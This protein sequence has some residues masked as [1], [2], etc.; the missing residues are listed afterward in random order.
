LQGQRSISETYT[1]AEPIVLIARDDAGNAP[2]ITGVI[3]ITPGVPAAI[4]LSSNPTWVGGN[5]HATISARLV[6]AFENGVPSLP[7]AFDLVSGTGTL[8]P[9][10]NTTDAAGLARADF[11]SPRQPE[12]DRIR[13]SS[14][15]L[16]SEI[17]VETAFVDPTAGGGTIASYPNPFH[18][19]ETASTIA[20]KL[21][22][23]AA[24]TLSI[25]TLSGDP[26]R[27]V[28]FARGQAG[29]TAGLNTWAWDGR[30]G[31]GK[32]VASGG[33]LVRVEARG[34]GETLHVMRRKIAVIH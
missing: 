7:M 1:F 23:V 32:Y 12:I 18:P 3:D 31:D 2:G 28:E 29:G 6:D 26:V 19:R 4:R 17:D 11:L 27:K 15:G 5:K 22:D 16:Q 10:D 33:Y 34:E 14:S 30:N 13:A 24:V 21:D 20:Y 9:V 25:F 8:T